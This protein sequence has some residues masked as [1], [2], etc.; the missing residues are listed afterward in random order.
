MKQNHVSVLDCTLRDGAYLLD[1]KFGDD[2]IKGIIAGLMDA[3]IDLIEIG[4]L[5]DEGFGEGKTVYRNSADARRFIPSDKNGCLFTVLADYSRYTIDNLDEYDGSSVDV[6]RECFFKEER[7]EAVEACKV[8]KNKGYKVFAQPVDILGYSDIELIELINMLNDVGLECFSIVDTFG[9]MYQED[10]VRIFE[11]VHHNLEMNC[12]VGFH[13]HNNLQLSSALSQEFVRMS[14][15]KRRVV[16]D[17][18]ISGMGRG[19]GNT[20][21]ELIAQYL[22]NKQNSLYNIDALLDVIDNYMNNIRTKCTW[23]YTTPLFVAGNYSA[24]TNN[25]NYLLQKNSI[26]SKDIRFILDIVGSEKRKRYDYDLLEKTY[27]EYMSAA[28]DDTVEF[29]KLKKALGNHNVLIVAPG[30]SIIEYQENIKALIASKNSIV[31]CVNGVIGEI[32]PDYIYMNNVKR[33][34][35][36]KYKE[37]ARK[38]NM[39][40]TSNIIAEDFENKTVISFNRIMRSGWRHSDNSVI[41]LLRLLDLLNVKSID[42]CGFDGYSYSNNYISE[43]MAYANANENYTELNMEIQQMLDE[44]LKIR[45]SA[46]EIQL[47]TPSRLFI[48]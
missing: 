15:G 31:I 48:A 46:C 13:S 34:E 24:H 33:F 16:V 8:I 25:V 23:G 17:G 19:A 26:Q 41:M 37:D 12:A 36:W 14:L 20:P 4:F 21:T 45:E 42:I 5:Q 27:I 11:I 3:Q 38:Y 9:S 29:D 22:V 28:I 2:T 7:F 39:I 35:A 47:I 30:A 10:L 40:L 18:T 32:T 43:G 6:V 1:K 44:Y